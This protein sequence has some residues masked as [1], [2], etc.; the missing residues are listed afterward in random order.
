MQRSFRDGAVLGAPC[1]ILGVCHE[2]VRGHLADVELALEDRTTLIVGHN[3][4]G[5]TSLS[6]AI[7]RFLVNPSPRL[8]NEDFFIVSHERDRYPRSIGAVATTSSPS[9]WYINGSVCAALEAG[10]PRRDSRCLPLVNAVYRGEWIKE[11]TSDKSP[12]CLSGG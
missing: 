9:R 6:E 8:E 5:K 1:P 2:G 3:N 10:E 11:R 12:K 4:S 7:R